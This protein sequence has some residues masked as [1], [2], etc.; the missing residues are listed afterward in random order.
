LEETL[1]LTCL[2]DARMYALLGR[3]DADL[4]ETTQKTG[5]LVCD[6]RLDRADYPRKPRGGPAGLGTGYEKRHSFCCDERGC[7]KRATP[8]SV[9]FLG[10]RVYLGAVVVLATALRHGAT[11]G[12]L[13]R[14]R[15]LL[16]VSARTLAR[17]RIWWRD[18][19][20]AT[21]FWRAARAR[22]NAPVAEETL[23]ASLLKRF[24]G[25]AAASVIHLLRFLGPLTVTEGRS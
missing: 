3:I 6:G 25:D 23:P 22:L 20:V 2:N 18:A 19:F 24:A 1:Y 5:C 10:R 4:A 14:L 12:R 21:R 15:G 8:P 13:A 7:R 11:P 17:W 16:G 9:R